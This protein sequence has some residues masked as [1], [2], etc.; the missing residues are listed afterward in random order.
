MDIH[1]SVVARD[2]FQ[3]VVHAARPNEEV[4]LSWDNL[5]H[6]P[7]SLRFYLV[8]ETT[9]A[10]RYMRTT[11]G[12][13]FRTGASGEDRRFRIE[14]DATEESRLRAQL[15]VLSNQSGAARFSLVL[16]KPATVSARM[17]TPSGKVAGVV[18]SGLVGRQGLNSLTWN[19]RNAAGSA[20]P[21][22]VYLLD[23]TVVDDDGQ[24]V[25]AVRSVT[26]R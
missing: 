17:L 11:T 16:N 9:G 22:G 24:E 8:D 25:R 10:R 4:T 23:V 14:V 3:L 5:G 21:R 13:T 26:V 7:K 6:A 15:D 19:G 1:A 12:Y 18:A 2:K 20:L